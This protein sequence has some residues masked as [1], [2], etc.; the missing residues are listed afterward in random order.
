MPRLFKTT[1][2]TNKTIETRTK[3]ASMIANMAPPLNPPVSGF[4]STII[5]KDSSSIDAHINRLIAYF[6]NSLIP[7]IKFLF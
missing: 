7:I 1:S 2:E 5:K 4:G 3:T 6:S